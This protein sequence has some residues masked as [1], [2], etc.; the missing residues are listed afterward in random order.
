M[1]NGNL[2]VNQVIYYFI[3]NII[4]IPFV[5]GYLYLYE[6]FNLEKIET[7]KSLTLVGVIVWHVLLIIITHLSA[8]IS[9]NEGEGIEDAILGAFKELAMYIK[10]SFNF[11]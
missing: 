3:L 8:K 9:S 7:V 1:R 4:S 5:F 11:K 2:L 10:V 6:R